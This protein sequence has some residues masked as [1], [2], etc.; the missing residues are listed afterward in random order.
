MIEMARHYY[1]RTLRSVTAKQL[2]LEA[3]DNSHLELEEIMGHLKWMCSEIAE[4][5]IGESKARAWIGYIQGE[6]RA[7]GLFSINELRAQS[8]ECLA[9]LGE[10]VVGFLFF[11]G[12][13][14]V[15][16]QKAKPEWQAG[17]LNGVGGLVEE[18]ETAEEAMRREYKEETGLE[19]ENWQ[20]YCILN[21]KGTRLHFFRS[22]NQDECHPAICGLPTEPVYWISVREVLDR[23]HKTI[24]NIPWLLEAA[25]NQQGIIE[26]WE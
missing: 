18:G 14:V 3:Y 13:D 21:T 9:P 10:Y 24:S 23:Q 1:H 4:G 8:R 11:G 2:P 7:A 20:K 6:L 5:R 15:L 12:H 25:L 26:V 17:K 19:V 22:H 16:V